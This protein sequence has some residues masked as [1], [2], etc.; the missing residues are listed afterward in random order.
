[1]YSIAYVG[2]EL[3]RRSLK[4]LNKHQFTLI[5]DEIFTIKFYITILFSGK[6]SF[7]KYKIFMFKYYSIY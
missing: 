5:Y 1:M 7:N 3:I 2:Y 6:L 4:N